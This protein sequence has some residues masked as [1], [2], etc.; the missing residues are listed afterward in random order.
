MTV[1]YFLPNMGE[2]SIQASGYAS[3]DDALDDRETEEVSMKRGKEQKL[4]V[5]CR[6]VGWKLICVLSSSSKLEVS[7]T[8]NKVCF[9]SFKGNCPWEG[10]ELLPHLKGTPET[11]IFGFDVLISDCF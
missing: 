3:G 6:M 2:L 11:L 5:G 7:L 8:P 1:L 10:G 4:M 9:D